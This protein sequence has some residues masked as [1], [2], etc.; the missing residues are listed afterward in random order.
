MP[1]TKP[2]EMKSSTFEKKHFEKLCTA[3]QLVGTSAF[4]RV[5]AT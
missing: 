3:F 5:A 2:Y 1:S 4:R